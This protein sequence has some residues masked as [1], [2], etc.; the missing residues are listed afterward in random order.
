MGIPLIAWEG[1]STLVLYCL[2]HIVST[3]NSAIVVIFHTIYN[4]YW[5]PSTLY[6]CI[7]LL[8]SSL[9]SSV[10][11][12]KIAGES[13]RKS[14]ER[15]SIFSILLIFN[16]L[17]E[18]KHSV[19]FYSY[20]WFPQSHSSHVT[21][22]FKEPEPMVARLCPM[23]MIFIEALPLHRGRKNNFLPTILSTNIILANKFQ[24]N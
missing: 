5:N 4:P 20:F 3:A 24:Q 16:Y 8:I 2:D 22:I 12:T 17:L 7:H 1:I 19:R 18:K 10:K 11:T 15:F 9:Y 13:P 23:S 14:A 21:S 6:S